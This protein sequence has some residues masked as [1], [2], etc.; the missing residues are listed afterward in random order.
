MVCQFNNEAMEKEA[1]S[2]ASGGY[3]NETNVFNPH[4]ILI[5]KW[6]FNCKSKPQFHNSEQF[7]DRT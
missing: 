7:L 2:G 1:A 4:P 6:N 3:R 5:S